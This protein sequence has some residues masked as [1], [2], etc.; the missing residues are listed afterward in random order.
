MPPPLSTAPP[1]RPLPPR[2]VLAIIAVG[3][4]LAGLLLGA[5]VRL[6]TGSESR[7]PDAGGQSPSPTQ[8][9]V[10]QSPSASIHSPGASEVGEATA[11]PPDLDPVPDPLPLSGSGLE[12]GAQIRMAA[13]PNESLYV[14]IPIGGDELIMLLDKDGQPR[15]GWPVLLRRSDYCSVLLVAPDGSVRVVCHRNESVDGLGDTI[16][17]AYA[18]DQDGDSLSGWPV[19]AVSEAVM[20]VM[21]GDDLTLL[22]RPYM[23]DT[24]EEGAPE[25]VHM[26]VVGSDGAVRSGVDVPF[27]CCDNAFAISPEGLGIISTREWSESGASVTT[28]LV[29][30][31][32]AGIRD[33]WPITLDGSSSE[34]AFDVDGAVHLVVGPP[35]RP[36]S[37]TLVLSADG[38]RIGG[39]DD[40]DIVSSLPW[41]GAGD[42]YPAAPIVA[43]DGSSLIVSTEDGGTTILALDPAGQP[44]P[45]WPY[46]S[47]LGIQFTGYCGEGDTGC[48]FYRTTM[49]LDERGVLYL[50]H[51]AS[52]PSA[53]GSVV[54]LGPDGRVR[55]GWPVGLSRAGSMFWAAAVDPEGGAYVLAIEP[56]PTGHSATIVA[57]AAD[58]TVRYTR[59][60]IEP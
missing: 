40:L 36:P 14:A 41:E 10:R 13:A 52:R 48:G 15:P 34:V 11:E 22:S 19:D 7:L 47:E 57:I 58:S 1:S 25:Y 45:G 20:G 26:D 9:P 42:P 37:R 53:G 4:I 23:G 55:D 21:V 16:T 35:Y 5:L 28:Q 43:P 44:R 50:L 2:R 59:T 8:P 17:R 54:A 18:F 12:L 39:S 38:R 30:F 51:A 56:E 24:L 27:A 49:A 33:G 3:A 6:N 31:D 29:A 46:R 60:I 32:E